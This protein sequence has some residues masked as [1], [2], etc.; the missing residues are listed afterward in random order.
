MLDVFEIKNLEDRWK[1]Y[2]RK[3]SIKTFTFIFVSL[4]ILMVS[5]YC[6]SLYIKKNISENH[7]NSALGI[8]K[9]NTKITKKLKISSK[10]IDNI[11]SKNNTAKSNI[12][13]EV[14]KKRKNKYNIMNVDILHLD[15]K[16]LKEVYISNS[17]N[18]KTKIDNLPNKNRYKNIAKEESREKNQ[19]RKIIISSKKIDKLKYFKEQYNKNQKAIYAIL[20]SKEYYKIRS[21]NKSLKWAIIANTIDSSNE[22]SWILFAKDKVKL[23]QKNDAINALNAYLK[24]NSSRKIETLLSNIKNGVFN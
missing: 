12:V 18:N 2:K 24:V 11:N 4:T 13:T 21:Y 15:K 3:K 23:G 22:E 19:K 16:F 17:D 9:E 14:D 6:V 5:I 7:K 20:I 1:K 10:P 8:K